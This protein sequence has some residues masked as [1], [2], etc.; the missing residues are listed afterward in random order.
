MLKNTILMLCLVF[1]SMQEVNAEKHAL[2]IAIGD[3][4]QEG[5]WPAISSMNDVPH[6]QGAL[7]LLGFPDENI[8][9][10]LNEAASREGILSALNELLVKAE[11][12]DIFFIHFSGHGQQVVD[13]DGDE[14]DGLDE[15]IVPFDSP[16][17]YV[18]GVYEGENLIRDEEMGIIFDELRAK[19]G[20]KGQV[21]L[22]LDSC[23]SGTGTRGMGKARGTASIMGPKDFQQNKVVRERSMNIARGS[24]ADLAPM[25]SFF[26]ASARELNFET[27]DQQSNPVGS[28][29]Y[30]YTS[31]LAQMQDAYTFEE[32]FDRIK[33]KMKVSAPRQNPQ[34]EGPS[35]VLIFG[36][37][38]SDRA[39]LYKVESKMGPRSYRVDVGTLE[40]VFPGSLLEVLEDDKE[41]VLI[42]VRVNVSFLT[43]SF[44]EVGEGVNL[45]LESVKWVR[46]KD[47]SYPS[48]SINIKSLLPDQEWEEVEDHI[49]RLPLSNFVN[50]N[51][52]LYLGEGKD[53]LELTTKEGFEI[54][55]ISRGASVKEL[56]GLLQAYAQGKFLRS[57]E[58]PNAKFDFKIELVKVDCET[59]EE[60]EISDLENGNLELYLGSCIRF[61]ITNQGITGAY[62]SL[63]DIQPDNVVNLVIPATSLGYTAEEYYLKA[64]ASFTT[65]YIVEIG[66]P[67]GL[68]TLKLIASKK[69]QDLSGIIASQGKS[70]RGFS[71]MDPFEQLLAASFGSKATRGAKV[72]QAK[73][74]ELGVSTLF[75]EI[76][77]ED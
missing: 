49:Q 62:F 8:H 18:K 31:V 4:P 60:L 2:V 65:D 6:V 40:G 7:G 24:T 45:D 44:I 14:L 33:L 51:A 26:G 53:G 37:E 66:A 48:I 16:L 74:D 57:Y 1:V 29:T 72:R 46:V 22:V 63:L 35:N 38:I 19:I 54:G 23:H 52:D 10:L 20:S 55:R 11:E 59:E 47:R 15:A 5:G 25:A 42:E 56:E 13:N 71:S 68:E 30:A 73:K 9:L 75:F 36:E 3:Y 77:Q 76:K 28:L 32:L 67:I 58:N 61:K 17:K 21:I 12:G 43:H 34:W 41:T 50:E 70:T 27:L 69:P 64:G 39:L